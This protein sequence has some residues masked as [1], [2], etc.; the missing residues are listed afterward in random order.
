MFSGT[1][2]FCTQHF[3]LQQTI[4]RATQLSGI[5]RFAVW[6]V[7]VGQTARTAMQNGCRRLAIRAE[8]HPRTNLPYYQH[9]S[10]H[11]PVPPCRHADKPLL[12][13]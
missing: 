3:R 4:Q 11:H 5:Q 6:V 2:D 9:Y 7:L 13:N 1:A 8:S 12:T 10:R